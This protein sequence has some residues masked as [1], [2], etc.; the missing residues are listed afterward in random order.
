MPMPR[1][2]RLPR[3]S[4]A[5]LLCGCTMYSHTVVESAPPRPAD[6]PVDIFH[7]PDVEPPTGSVPAAALPPHRTLG[8]I[9]VERSLL[10][11]VDAAVEKAKRIARR[12][13][14]DAIV[15]YSRR[16]FNLT[17]S[18]RAFFRAV[19]YVRP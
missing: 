17:H 18:P 7:D 15:L 14:A 6:A 12:M 4:F 16:G 2:P 11:G 8:V 10:L 1:I 19:G 9:E 13:G 5:A 3:V